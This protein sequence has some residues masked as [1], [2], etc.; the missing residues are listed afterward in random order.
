MS[1]YIIPIRYAFFIFPIIAALFTIPYV[2][3][4]YHKYGSIPSLRIIVVY[5]F[6]L[7]LITS[8]F[9]VI[10]PLPTI[11]EV[12]NLKTPTTQLIP[13][14]FVVDFIEHTSFVISNPSTYFKALTEPWVYQILYNILLFIPFGIYLRYYF[15]CSLKKTVL[16]SFL[17]SLFFEL[18]QL[19]GLYGYYPR[20]YRLF[21]VD[22]LMINTL[23]G[24]IGYYLTGIIF[25]ILPT[26]DKLDQY[27]YEIGERITVWKRIT[28]LIID[29]TLMGILLIITI[30][31]CSLFHKVS[32][33]LIEKIVVFLYFVVIPSLLKGQT[34]GKKFLNMKLVTLNND[35]AKP[36]QYFFRYF[37]LY[38][39]IFPL[40][41]YL[42]YGIS[43]INPLFGNQTLF[44]IVGVI[45]I[46]MGTFLYYLIEFIQM[47]KGNWLWYERLTRTQN[48]ST[49]PEKLQ[50]T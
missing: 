23:G 34:L 8:Y 19:S 4:Q 6:I 14:Q 44:T 1:N 20:G 12:M 2:L 39:V 10:L 36:Y 21:D 35:E 45:I 38:E 37:I 26:R 28:N 31:V 27:A 48:K 46:F 22:D 17:L 11:D 47:L 40:P 43:I 24:F 49:I 3:V 18:T 15:K 29:L 30:I 41:F 33:L 16:Y 5:S 25:K 42:I 50:G 7:Y 9:L 13:F 32:Y